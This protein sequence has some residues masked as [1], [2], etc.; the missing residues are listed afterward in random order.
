MVTDL[1]SKFDSNNTRTY[2][3]NTFC[4]INLL[5]ELSKVIFAASDSI[6]SVTLNWAV[7]GKPS[8]YYKNIEVKSSSLSIGLKFNKIRLFLDIDE[9]TLQKLEFPFIALNKICERNDD[10]VFDCFID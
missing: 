9:A 10:L 7:I 8:T 2:N 4:S 1:S 6:N 5:G 3:S